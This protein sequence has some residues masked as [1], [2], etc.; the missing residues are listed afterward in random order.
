MAEAKWMEGKLCDRH[1]DLEE[2]VVISVR[3][4]GMLP[5]FFGS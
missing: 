1:V 4:R 3:R 5:S 2:C